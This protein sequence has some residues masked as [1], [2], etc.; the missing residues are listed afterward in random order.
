MSATADRRRTRAKADRLT[1]VLDA[2]S[3]IDTALE[4]M[5]SIRWPSA[6]YRDDPVGFFRDI[7]GAEPWSKQREVLESVRDNP[8][9]SW[10]A[11]H[12]V[13]KHLALDTPVPTPTGW[14]TIGDIRP[15]DAVFDETGTPRKVLGVSDIL[16]GEPCYEVEFDDGTTVVTSGTHAWKTWTHR[17][18]KQCDRKKRPRRGPG[19]LTTTERIR[20][21][22]WTKHA[23]RN[24][25]IVTAEPIQCEPAELPIDPYLLGVWLGDGASATGSVTTGDPEVVEAFAR[26]GYD[27]RERGKRGKA[28]C[29]AAAR[30]ATSPSLHVQLRDA[31][32]L[33]NKHV[34]QQYLRAS[35]DQRRD[36]LAGLL[37]SDGHTRPD[38]RVMFTNTNERVAL[39]V[40]ELAASLGY[41]P[42]WREYRAMLNGV[43][44]GPCYNV[45]F[46]THE[47]VC[48]LERKNR[49]RRSPR[50]QWT[51]QRMV[52]DVRPTASV[53]VRCI[54]VDSPS[55]LF[56]VSRA[57]IPTHNSHTDS[58]AALWFYSS[59]ED[60]RVVMTAPVARQVDDILYRELR[61]MVRRAGKCAACRA[62]DPEDLRIP[63]PCPHSALIDGELG[64]KAKTGLVSKNFREIKGYTAKDVESITGTAGKNLLFIIDESSGVSDA[65]FEGLE[66]NR[67]GWSEGGTGVV[68][69]LLSGNPT[70]TSGEF[71]RSHHDEKVSAHYHCITTSSEESPNV[72]AGKEII[73]GLATKDWVQE[74]REMW[75]E[76]SALYKVRVKGEFA[77]DED[78]KIF[79]VH[80]IQESEQR[81]EETEASGRLY[82]GVDPAGESGTGDEAA[83]APRRGLKLL[84]LQAERGLSEAEHLV[85]VLG[86][87]EAHGLPRETPVVVLDRE[88]AV[89]AK[90]YAHFV[91]YLEEHPHAFELV[92]VRA[93]DRA[94]RQPYIYDRMR[95]ELAANLEA[96]VRDGGAIVEDTKL[97]A[98]MHVFEWEQHVNGRLKL[99]P[100][101]K[102][103]RK[104]SQLGR[105]PDR[106]DAV[107]HSC[108]EPL[109][110]RGGKDLPPSV[111]RD[112]EDEFAEVTMDP[113]AAQD[114]WG[115]G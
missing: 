52:A 62:E 95:D 54:E 70:K 40:Y 88:G 82:I 90:V 113:Y 14:T 63:R 16:F 60:A 101:K 4:A 78:G 50:K 100:Q 51:K 23:G 74:K 79:S 2:C 20:D 1:F 107:A 93:S 114:T 41:K 80:A 108:W 84:E 58:G 6:R 36:L 61:M 25:A 102:D 76:D 48:R 67:A 57:F 15:G 77:L 68:R 111:R 22:L 5:T 7:L 106:F 17:A 98:E 59:F 115:R 66:G 44:C 53:P 91:G 71:F 3:V 18:R 92:A 28:V 55:H 42:H 37:D 104:S 105:S 32:L 65:I 96:W 89:G 45:G 13:S 87:I 103:L 11:G 75:G 112:A 39:G 97:A 38:G 69:V 83:F 26:A 10:K 99:V 21:S 46:V 49:R 73:P 33:R 27:I 34:P 47:P 85:R 24:H 35:E 31:G 9:T 19:E 94:M 29:F 56:L 72:V 8:R 30:S 110:L 43:D 109:A 12:R 81:W 86:L 64:E